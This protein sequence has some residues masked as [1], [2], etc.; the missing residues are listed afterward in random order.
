MSAGY[1]YTYFFYLIEYVMNPFWDI[2]S[3]WFG[4]KF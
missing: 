1:K 2:L 3:N 4:L